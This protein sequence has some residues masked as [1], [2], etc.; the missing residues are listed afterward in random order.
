MWGNWWEVGRVDNIWA[1]YVAILRVERP[2]GWA[3]M[4]WRQAGR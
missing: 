3:V 2:E 1:S 4:T